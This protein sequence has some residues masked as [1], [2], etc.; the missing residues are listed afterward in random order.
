MKATIPPDVNSPP[1]PGYYAGKIRETIGASNCYKEPPSY[2]IAMSS[3]NVSKPLPRA[4]MS[5]YIGIDA[6]FKLYLQIN[7]RTNEANAIHELSY[8]F[9]AF[10]SSDNS[11]L[12]SQPPPMFLQGEN[13]LDTLGLNININQA[14]T[15]NESLNFAHTRFFNSSPKYGAIGL[16]SSQVNNFNNFGVQLSQYDN[17]SYTINY[18][19]GPSGVIDAVR[20]SYLFSDWGY[21]FF[22]IINVNRWITS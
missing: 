17:Q 22:F 5:L 2:F 9:F 21:S 10:C 12:L 15:R 18:Y 20:V 1:G 13:E 6:N 11:C 7:F 8:A 3:F 14:S 19:V 16:T 4:D